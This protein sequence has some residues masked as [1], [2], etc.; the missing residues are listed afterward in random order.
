MADSFTELNVGTGGSK[1]DEESLTVS[2]TTVKR[3]RIQ[4]AGSSANEITKVTNSAPS[5]TDYAAVIRPIST[6]STIT[7]GRKSSIST[8]AVQMTASSITAIQGVQ[9]KAAD[10]NSDKIYVGPS[11]VTADS[12]DSTDGYPLAPGDAILVPVNNANVIYLIAGSGT[13]KAFFLV[14]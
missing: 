1:I 8:S 4:V 7:T 2:A 12:S 10:T 14:L 3:S 6:G 5:S 13:Q 9:V 11:G